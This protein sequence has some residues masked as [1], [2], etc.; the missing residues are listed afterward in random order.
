M[1]LRF[2]TLTGLADGN[3]VRNSADASS[4]LAVSVN[5]FL[6]GLHILWFS[7]EAGLDFIFG[8]KGNALGCNGPIQCSESLQRL[9]GISLEHCVSGPC[10]FLGTPG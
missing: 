2:C 10:L 9:G 5:F 1:W 8:N 6:W 3:L 4:K 7:E